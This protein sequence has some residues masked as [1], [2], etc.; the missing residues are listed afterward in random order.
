MVVSFSLGETLRATA[1]PLF[2]MSLTSF[3]LKAVLNCHFVKDALCWISMPNPFVPANFDIVGLNIG[4]DTNIVTSTILYFDTI[5]VQDVVVTHFA[6]RREYTGQMMPLTI[7]QFRF[8]SKKLTSL[9]LYT[10]STTFMNSNVVF[11]SSVI[12]SPTD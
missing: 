1:S 2:M 12:G 11:Y 5:H 3:S 4:V 6:S 9:G 7:R 8:I 10:K